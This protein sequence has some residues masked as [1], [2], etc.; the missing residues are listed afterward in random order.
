MKIVFAS[1]P[2]YGHLY[3]ILPLAQACA[4]AGH[5]VLI[6]TG[7]PFLDALPLPTARGIVA[8]ATLSDIE[9][10]TRRNH[11]D[12]PDGPELAAYLFGET[13]KR[14]TEPALTELLEKERP[15]LVVHEIMTLAAPVAA[16]R[17]KIP[18]IAFGTGLWS[19]LFKMI[20][21][22]AGADPTLPAGYLDPMP[23]SVQFPVPLP[24]SRRPI[25]P[26]AWAPPA[27]MPSWLPSSPRRRVY[28]TLGTVAYG[29]VEVLRRA[30]LAVATQDVE[31]LVAVG[32]AGDPG[33]LGDL[34]PNVHLEKF[35]PQAE[36][37]QHVDLVVHHGGAGTMLGVLAAGLPQLILPQGADQ[38]FNA[39]AIERAGAGRALPNDAQTPETLEEAI[40]ALL[41]DGPERQTAKQIATEIAEMPAPSPALLTI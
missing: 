38:P 30:V 18:S 12:L 25:R 28:V 5:K 26:V 37:L 11:P 1:L 33:L 24:A 27:P 32:P 17:L 23:Q 2:A 41:A 7:D 16:A 22:V 20:Y 13:T 10:E 21:E 9:D 40:T 34:P 35:V 36:V 3:P 19:P 31:V 6:A 39:Q 29:A 15:D 8:N 4:D 14:L